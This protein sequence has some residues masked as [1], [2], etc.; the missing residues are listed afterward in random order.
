[1]KE[2]HHLPLRLFACRHDQQV[3]LLFAEEAL[4]EGR[5]VPVVHRRFHRET[6]IGSQLF[7][8]I[9]EEISSLLFFLFRYALQRLHYVV[10]QHL[11]LNNM[12]G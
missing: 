8:L 6:R 7:R 3:L 1:M 11:L 5:R 12:T 9:F 2:A 10:H 4:D